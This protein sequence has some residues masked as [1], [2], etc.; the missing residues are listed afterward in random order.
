MATV[1][2]LADAASVDAMAV[3]SDSALTVLVESLTGVTNIG[4]GVYRTDPL[5]YSLYTIGQVYY[6][7]VTWT[8]VSATQRSDSFPFL[9]V[10]Q[11][12]AAGAATVTGTDCDGKH[13]QNPVLMLRLGRGDFREAG[14]ENGKF[15][16]ADRFVQ[17]LPLPDSVEAEEV[18]LLISSGRA[19]A[20]LALERITGRR[21]TRDEGG[22]GEPDD[23]RIDLPMPSFHGGG[24]RGGIVSVRHYLKH[25]RNISIHGDI[26]RTRPG[27]SIRR[28]RTGV[29][30]AVFTERI[31]ADLIDTTFGAVLFSGTDFYTNAATPAALT[32]DG[33]AAVTGPYAAAGN[34]I[35]RWVWMLGR[36]VWVDGTDFRLISQDLAKTAFR[37]KVA[38]AD[39][40]TPTLASAGATFTL[41]TGTY[42][43]RVRGYDEDTGTYSGPSQRL[44][45]AATQAVL[46]TERLQ[47]TPASLP[48]RWTHWQ[49][50]IVKLSPQVD[51]PA[52]Y[53]IVED[54]RDSSSI[55]IAAPGT[56]GLIPR[57]HTTAY[58][59]A[60]PASGAQF[61]FRSIAGISVYR[62]ANPPTGAAHVCHYNGRACYASAVDTW[63][64]LSETGNPEHFYTDPTSPHEGFNTFRGEGKNDSIASPCKALVAT[65]DAVLFIME[66]GINVFEG[67]FVL[68]V[69][70]DG[71]ATSG[72][73]DIR[74]RPIAENTLGA[75]TNSTFVVDQEVYYVSQEGPAVFMG[76]A[77]VLLDA[78]AV[79]VDWKCRDPV[80]DHRIRVG[81][82]PDTD[83]VLFSFVSLDTSIA[84]FPDVTLA[85]HRGKKAWCPPFDLYAC[86][87]TMHRDQDDSSNEK[88]TKL[89][90]GGPYASL[91]E[92]GVGHG[93]GEDGSDTDAEDLAST[94]DTTLT[95]DVSGK[96]WT[97]DEWKH[98]GLVLTDRTTGRRYYK[99]VQTNDADTLTWE[100]AVTDAGGGWLLDLGGIRSQIHVCYISH[101]RPCSI[102]R[103][104]AHLQDQVSLLA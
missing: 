41:A 23:P 2:S 26:H 96:A 7:K 47:V 101:G 94:S 17:E 22:T 102:M 27:F 84:G 10:P 66:R 51:V 85:Y 77:S 43:V 103:L 12:Q 72:A 21:K 20:P 63:F 61:E 31:A 8:P 79:R 78:E 65:K 76:G 89:F 75:I 35:P 9:V 39:P 56:E 68:E 28:A 83:C 52:A 53:E 90:F 98:K 99:V 64:V 93:D 54:P 24:Y 4:T 95:A 1:Y 81:Y 55:A 42:A 69:S 67:S 70:A 6:L 40:G 46:S 33:Y 36:A 44:T 25:S 37:A 34:R 74:S 88:G 50:Q 48:A 59:E 38:M 87:W 49:I 18:H 11:G 104:R 86:S 32:G 82:D 57:A 71:I 92:Y 73:R 15:A 29:T 14:F 97:T 13:V 80:Y 16:A 5:T 60:D 19:G 58:V 100:G 30:T 91:N 45:D 3:Y 62:H